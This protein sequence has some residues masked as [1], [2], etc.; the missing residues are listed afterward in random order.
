MGFSAHP[1]ANE[2]INQR[3]FM[4]PN[5]FQQFN[6]SDY[7]VFAQPVPALFPDR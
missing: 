6:N 3:A 2:M 1:K 4:Q 5:R 7:L